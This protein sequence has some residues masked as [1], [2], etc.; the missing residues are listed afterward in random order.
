[1]W[2]E[3]IHEAAST[4]QTTD[5]LF[6]HVSLFAKDSLVNVLAKVNVFC[7]SNVQALSWFSLSSSPCQ[8]TYLSF[9]L[10]DNVLL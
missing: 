3:K 7:V 4:L 6:A 8:N 1:M 5:Y 9:F 10:Y 2:Q